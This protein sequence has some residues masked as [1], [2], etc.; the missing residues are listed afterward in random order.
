METQDQI[1]KKVEKMGMGE[2][3]NKFKE[4]LEAINLIKL[5]QQIPE[6]SSDLLMEFYDEIINE[7]EKRE[8]QKRPEFI[9]EMQKRGEWDDE[10]ECIKKD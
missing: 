3:V 7:I 6:A 2:K 4:T 8:Q 5:R 10:A 9:T 1:I